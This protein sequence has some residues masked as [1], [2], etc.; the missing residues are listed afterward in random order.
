MIICSTQ[1]IM[2][3]FMKYS[4]A[5]SWICVIVS[6]KLIL[7]ACFAPI[8][9]TQEG[10]WFDFTGTGEIGDTIGGT[11]GPIVA[12]AGVLMTFIAF[13]MQVN[14]NK[15]QSGQLKA[16][17]NMKLLEGKLESRNA[18]ELMN[19]DIKGMINEI[20]LTCK[21]IDKFCA[22]TDQ[23]PFGD[24]PFHFSPCIARS[25]YQ[26]IDRNLLYNSFMN[27]VSTDSRCI[28]FQNVYKLMDFYSEGLDILRDNIY[29]PYTDDITTIREQLPIKLDALSKYIND[30]FNDERSKLLVN[31][32]NN[33]VCSR[34]ITEGILNCSKLYNLLN[35]QRFR[36][37][38]EASGNYYRE[39]L[40]LSNM[41]ITKNRMFSKE[42]A[43]TA[44]QFK[45]QD[46]YERLVS[47]SEI[48]DSSLA[49]YTRES[50]NRQFEIECQGII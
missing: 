15:I 50:I 25:R 5:I 33:E 28:E 43:N 19:M 3:K 8:I 9:F 32:F 42:L 13:L 2:N 4:Y 46:R 1:L 12:I 26:T 21:E 39:L 40:G 36:L 37:L 47:I 22:Y 18:L 20:D 38:Y 6:A 16:S 17:F 49:K 11:M 41:L 44:V 31:T 27:F 34:V 7:F 23:S 24:I 10:E 30:Q 48:I 29:K 14:A 35:D 45:H